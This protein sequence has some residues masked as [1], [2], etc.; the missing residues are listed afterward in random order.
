[1]IRAEAEGTT[2]SG[3]V[4]SGRS[5]SPPSSY[6]SGHWLLW[7][8][9]QHLP[10]FLPSFLSFFLFFFL[11]LSSFL[12]F[13]FVFPSFLFSSLLFSFLSFLFSAAAAAAAAAAR[14]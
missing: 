13:S 12:L 9:H 11:S 10:S 14:N 7:Q 1:M 6:F 3:P 4:C 2:L 8:C 5:V